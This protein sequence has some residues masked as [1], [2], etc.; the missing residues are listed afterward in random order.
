MST[1]MLFIRVLVV[2]KKESMNETINLSEQTINSVADKMSELGLKEFIDFFVLFM[3]AVVAVLIARWLQNKKEEKDR[4]YQNKFNVFATILGLR[5]AKGSEENF[6]IAMNQIPIVFHGNKKVMEYL[7]TF[8]KNH[9]DSSATDKKLE[10]LKSDLNDLVLEMA[11]DLGY[12]EIDNNVMKS[13]F[14]PD[15]SFFRHQASDIYNEKYAQEHLK[16]LLELRESS[17]QKNQSDDQ[18]EDVKNS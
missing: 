14:N 10:D 5:H 3:S 18:Q 6:V 7:K 2:I 8:I 9:Q 17:Q 4:M 15:T 1:I 12:S 16:H 13:F 11:R